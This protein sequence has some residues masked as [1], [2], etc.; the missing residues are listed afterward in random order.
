MGTSAVVSTSK[1]VSLVPDWLRG[2]QRQFITGDLSAGL[3]VTVMLIPQSLAYA[4][5]AGLP[6]QVGLYASILPLIAYAFFG[7]SMTLAVGPVAVISLM[8]ASALAP[9]AA[10]GSELYVLLAAQLAFLIG[11]FFLIFG[12]LRLGFLSH[13]LSHSVINGFIMG[14]AILITVGQIKHLLGIKIANGDVLETVLGIA[15]FADQTN[16]LTLSIAVA[17]LV[18]LFVAQKYLPDFLVRRGLSRQ[19]SGLVSKLV[20]MLAVIVSTLVI[21]SFNWHL[22]DG[23]SVVGEVPKGIP[24]LNFVLP[25]A[26]A[27]KMLWLPALLIALI[28]FVESVSIAQSLALKRNQRIN[29]NKELRGLG[30]ANIA[31]AISGGYPVTGGF[32]RSV[33]NFNAGA[34]TPLAGVIS[35][36]LMIVVLLSFTDNFQTLPQA[37][38]SATIII[39]VLSLVDIKSIR[40]TWA[41]DK[42]DAIALLSTGVGVIFWGVEEGVIIGVAFSLAAY[43]WKAGHPHIAIVGRV[44]G[45]EHFRNIERHPV[46]DFPNILALRVDENLFFGNVQVIEDLIYSKIKD[47]P[48]LQNV[49][50]IFSAV[51]RVDAT[52]LQTLADVNNTLSKQGIRFHLAEVK[53]PVMDKLEKTNFIREM[54]GKCFLSTHEAI[55]ALATHA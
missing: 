55:C 20:P 19:T 17:V 36:L 37:T 24:D 8:T 48:D 39:A 31:S 41:Y 30:A 3:I 53:G 54:S 22:T 38:L 40:E 34:N 26:A 2:Y 49:V 18:V 10:S 16:L 45:T 32:S 23:V 11:C 13:L 35:A 21:G 52:A 42:S 43:V 33:V 46:E 4:L 9:L 5:I 6:P 1:L 14:S 47:R 28:S 29:A 27:F 51:N 7:S 25:D 12:I 50:L 44:K 15:R